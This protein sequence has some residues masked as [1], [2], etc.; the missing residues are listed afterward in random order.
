MQL[1]FC[2]LQLRSQCII[3]EHELSEFIKLTLKVEYSM[4]LDHIHFE[5]K[6]KKRKD[7]NIIL[8]MEVFVL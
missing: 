2:R 1:S 4:T 6:G 8:T 5:S 7:K 3:E